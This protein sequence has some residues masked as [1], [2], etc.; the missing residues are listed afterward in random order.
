MCSILFW[1]YVKLHCCKILCTF[2]L[3]RWEISCTP[4][5]FEWER[6]KK[7]KKNNAK[8]MK[9]EQKLWSHRHG[10]KKK[11]GKSGVRTEHGPPT[12]S[13]N[14]LPTELLQAAWKCILVQGLW[15]YGEEV[16]KQSCVL[17]EKCWVLTPN[18]L[19]RKSS[20]GPLSY[21]KIGAE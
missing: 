3:S 9:R 5:I 12:P 13:E 6:R 4:L 10:V 20:E 8:A 21:C 18:I 11:K 7:E 14:V 2:S 17:Q 16:A 19:G 15:T 1:W